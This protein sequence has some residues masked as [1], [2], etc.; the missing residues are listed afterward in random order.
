MK[1]VTGILVVLLGLSCALAESIIVQ[2]RDGEVAVRHGVTEVWNTVS[3]GDA[4]R[5]NDTVRT[6]K[7]GSAVLIMQGQSDRSQKKLTLPPSVIVDMSDI[8]ELSQEELMLKLTMEK[9][10]ASSTQ[11]KSDGLHIPNAAVTHGEPA[12]SGEAPRE[13]DPQIGTF[14][15]NGTRFLLEHGYYATGVLR[16]LEVFRM[17]PSLGSTYDHRLML[18]EAMEKANLKGEALAEY[19]AMTR[20]DGLSTAQRTQLQTRMAGLRK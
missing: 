19:G 20:M 11:W 15:L 10:R 17:Y 8:R 3:V 14:L 5:P 16:T 1:T 7:D 13:N 9:V 12:G 4:L 6:G 2:K 18:A